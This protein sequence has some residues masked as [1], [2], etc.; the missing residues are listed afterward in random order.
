MMSNE[1]LFVGARAHDGSYGAVAR[2]VDK[3][4]AVL[5][6]VQQQLRASSRETAASSVRSFTLVTMV[7][8]GCCTLCGFGLVLAFR[9]INVLLRI[10][11][12]T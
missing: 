8:I 2:E 1:R 10:L 5:V 12:K 9:K 7:L 6:E 4:A 11:C 3:N